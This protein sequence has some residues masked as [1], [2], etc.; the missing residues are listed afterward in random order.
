MRDL[1][2]T[3]AEYEE[4]RMLKFAIVEDNESDAR[5]LES[6]LRES[7]K[8]MN[9]ECTIEKYS[10]AES[11]NSDGREYDVI[12]LDIEMPGMN[13]MNLAERIRTANSESGIVFVTNMVRYAVQGYGVAPIDYIVKPIERY[14]FGIT[15]KRVLD[16][17]TRK[18][19]LESIL[20][21]TRQGAKKVCYR[22]IRYIDVTLH[23]IIFYTDTENLDMWGTL[24]D[25]E[26][27]LPNPPFFRLSSSCIVNLSY[28]KTIKGYDVE[29]G[30][31]VLRT[32]R[33]RKKEL[34]IALAEYY[35]K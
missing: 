21:K 4:K 30:D 14:D 9:A 15:I 23:H 8:A 33:S 24:G 28:I 31:V 19:D 29:V 13:G 16:F 18:N 11:F 35:G 32:A 27:K 10:N 12:F 2:T 20:I 17:C 1:R 34:L 3:T 22:Q 6:N 26:E 25:V 5:T 7:L